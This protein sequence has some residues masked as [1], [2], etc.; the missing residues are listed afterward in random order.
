VYSVLNY[1][2]SNEDRNNII[3]YI[4][5][6]LIYKCVKE[7]E[8]SYL[9]MCFVK[10]YDQYNQHQKT[11]VLKTLEM[12][13]EDFQTQY[14]TKVRNVHFNPNDFYDKGQ[15][16]D[17]IDFKTNKNFT[18]DNMCF[19]KT[20]HVCSI[21]WENLVKGSSRV[22]NPS[23]N[24]AQT[25]AQDEQIHFDDDILEVRADFFIQYIEKPEDRIRMMPKETLRT[26]R[27]KM[28][29]D[30]N[31]RFCK[32]NDD[33]MSYNDQEEAS[34]RLCDITNNP[35]ILVTRLQDSFG[36]SL[37][38][39]AM[40]QKKTKTSESEEICGMRIK[41]DFKV[42]LEELRKVIMVKAES[43]GAEGLREKKFLFVDREGYQVLQCEENE[44]LVEEI[45][46]KKEGSIIVN[47]RFV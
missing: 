38:R 5:L 17:K 41:K 23:Q 45:V 7:I 2:G 21:K 6:N 22:I 14:L 3:D 1:Q 46:I 37:I 25:P 40:C 11:L 19:D 33:T 24:V 27:D 44:M 28:N 43:L 16:T 34:L 30:S 39:V 35:K 47:I 36:S 20:G 13:L 31:L 8:K 42:Q 18:I 29:L 26:L 9:S 15:F 32:K 12:N 4:N 10:I